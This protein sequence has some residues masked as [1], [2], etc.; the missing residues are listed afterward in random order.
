ME[1][2]I[3]E[4]EELERKWLK[5][6]DDFEDEFKEHAA[7]FFDEKVFSE[8]TWEPS[9]RY[10]D[11]IV[12]TGFIPYEIQ[13]KIS[14][15]RRSMNVTYVGVELRREGVSGRFLVSGKIG[16]I[17]W[18][19]KMSDL[20][21]EIERKSIQFPSDLKRIL[22]L[23]RLTVEEGKDNVLKRLKYFSDIET[24]IETSLAILG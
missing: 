23:K 24:N 1:N 18:E 19:V 9:S 12:F 11:S 13:K 10:H 6:R 15:L 17:I 22:K 3:S 4:I 21:D 2:R 14:N 5:A 7:S 20:R 8:I 16:E